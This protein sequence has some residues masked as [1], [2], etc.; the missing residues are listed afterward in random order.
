MLNICLVVNILINTVSKLLALP[1]TWKKL[2]A[3][4]LNLTN[5][6]LF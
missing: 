6:K 4:A 5:E 2:E 3:V 1:S